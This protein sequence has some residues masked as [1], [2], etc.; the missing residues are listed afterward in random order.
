MKLSD[1]PTRP[2]N[3]HTARKKR[4]SNIRN[5]YSCD[6]TLHYNMHVT[7][8]DLNPFDTVRAIENL[9]LLLTSLSK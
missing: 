6:L 1:I 8:N 9:N 3:M 5:I 7:S 2:F 4:L